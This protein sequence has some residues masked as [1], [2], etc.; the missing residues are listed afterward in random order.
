MTPP[1]RAFDDVFDEFDDAFDDAFD[2]EFDDT[3]DDA[4]DDTLDGVFDDAFDED[5]GTGS[6]ELDDKSNIG[7]CTN[8]DDDDDE[9]EDA[10]GV[11]SEVRHEFRTRPDETYAITESDG[12][13]RSREPECKC[14]PTSGATTFEAP[15]CRRSKASNAS[16][17]VRS[18]FM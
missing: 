10:A 6:N 5:D 14:E 2:D 8:T 17:R 3:F 15:A 13:V 1:M 12:E 18:G 4:L 7:A 11:D 9:D 16:V